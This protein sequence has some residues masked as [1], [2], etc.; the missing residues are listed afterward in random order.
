VGEDPDRL[1]ADLLELTVAVTVELHEAIEHLRRPGRF[2]PSGTPAAAVFDHPPG[3]EQP[4]HRSGAPS[5]EVA[6]LVSEAAAEARDRLGYGRRDGNPLLPALALAAF[7]LVEA[8]RVG[9]LGLGEAASG[10]VVPGVVEP[11]LASHDP[12]LRPG[13]AVL[14]TWFPVEGAPQACVQLRFPP[15]EP[16]T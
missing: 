5:P 12:V 4:R 6:A 13:G 14:R 3:A 2:E 10:R 11:E 8:R 9:A 16:S 1:A 15:P 7:Y